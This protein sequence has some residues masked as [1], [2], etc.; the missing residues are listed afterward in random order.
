MATV[1]K[2][3]S[4]LRQL[5]KLSHA[6]DSG[7]RAN[8][9]LERYIN[10]I[11]ETEG[12]GT[13]IAELKKRLCSQRQTTEGFTKDAVALALKYTDEILN[14]RDVTDRTIATEAFL[15]GKTYIAIAQGIGFSED[16][17]KKRIKKIIVKIAKSL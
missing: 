11:S 17:I 3:R 6:I 7:I 14:L 8:S 9:R 10:T 12:E 5:R 4:E 15:N 13:H 16:G 2:V 1:E